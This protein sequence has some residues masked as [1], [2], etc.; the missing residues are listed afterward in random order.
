MVVSQGC[1]PSDLQIQVTDT[2]EKSGARDPV[3]EVEVKN[4]CSCAVASVFL[5]SRGFASSIDVDP[6]LFRR[7]GDE[8]LVNDGKAIASS[9]SVKFR[10]AWDRPF[11]MAP[12]SLQAQC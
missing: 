2:G 3:F 1:N 6:T 7:Q 5:S 4:L 10:Y 9:Q 11:A 8:Y 12:A